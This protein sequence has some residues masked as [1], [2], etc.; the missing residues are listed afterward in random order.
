MKV[1]SGPAK[2][3]AM[4]H[5][6]RAVV[7]LGFALYFVYDGAVGYHAKNRA[8]AEQALQQPAVFNGQVSFED[9]GERPTKAEFDRLVQSNPTT[10]Q[11][12]HEALGTPM[13]EKGPDQYFISIFGYAQVTV[14]GGRVNPANM[15]WRPWNKT[16]EEIQAQFFWAIVPAL[17]G[18]YFLWRLFRGATLRVVVDDDGMTYGG[19]R[20]AFDSMVS[21]RDYNPKGW[22]DL[23]H[24]S[25][26]GEKRLRLDNEKVARFDEIVAAICEVKGFKNEVQAYAEQKTREDEGADQA[27][28][29]E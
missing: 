3:D 7:F 6:G 19:R 20:V 12:V 16:Q 17:P 21:L 26:G 14:A 13:F 11:Q 25:G 24:K 5:L 23:Y 8:A 27:A 2:T 18:L 15:L 22:I 10:R 4:W 1:E 9:L 29:E 28:A